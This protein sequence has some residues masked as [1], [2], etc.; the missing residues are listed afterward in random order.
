MRR[1]PFSLALVCS[2]SPGCLMGTVDRVDTQLTLKGNHV[3]SSGEKVYSEG[4]SEI[5]KEKDSLLT[6]LQGPEGPEVELLEVG[7]DHLELLKNKE[8]YTTLVKNMQ[9]GFVEQETYDAFQAS[10]GEATSSLVG[11]EANPR[12]IAQTSE[13]GVEEIWT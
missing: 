8:I 13:A 9:S 10:Q 7:K 4:A 1:G 5:V 6:T 12:H 2:A 3:A 11:D